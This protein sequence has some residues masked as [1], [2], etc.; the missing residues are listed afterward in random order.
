MATTVNKTAKLLSEMSI[1]GSDKPSV[2]FT[3]QLAKKGNESVK[4]VVEE[5]ILKANPRRF[6]LFPINYHEVCKILVWFGARAAVSWRVFTNLIT[7]TLTL[8][9]PE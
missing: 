7:W 3:S 2:Q 5:P 8:L 6:V 1:H 9:T 4:L